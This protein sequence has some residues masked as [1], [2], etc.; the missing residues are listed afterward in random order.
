MSRA[1]AILLCA[2]AMLSA[3]PAVAAERSLSVTSF[4]RIRVD[5]PFK[6]TLTTGVAPFARVT[7][8]S[9]ALDR[10]SVDV[11]GRTLVVRPSLS[12]W[13]GY[14]GAA[15]GPAEILLG[16]HDLSQAWLNGAGSL[17]IDRVRGLSFGLDLQ[18][19]GSIAIANVD[20][21]Q[22]RVGLNGAASATLAG[23]APRLTAIVRGVSSLD[24]G[25]L[26][27]KDAAI[28]AEGPAQVK[29]S[30]TGTLK[31]DARGTSTI[32][33]AGNPSCTVTA[34]GSAIVTGCR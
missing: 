19:P 15:T 26:E 21:D 2:I 31:L 24:A 28:G 12:S 7:G 8:P 17:S 33:V 13:G 9:A 22:L 25:G 11:Q 1:A 10:V 30:V 32:D 3:A 34:Q 23:K 14:P 29:A 6:V 16:T 27:V 4:D 5:G 20:V 18:G